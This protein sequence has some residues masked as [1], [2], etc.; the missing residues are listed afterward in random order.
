M[1]GRQQYNTPIPPSPI[2]SIVFIWSLQGSK[3]MA[4]QFNVQLRRYMEYHKGSCVRWTWR[5][6][7][8]KALLRF[9]YISLLIFPVLLCFLDGQTR[10]IWHCQ[11]DS[12]AVLSPLESHQKLVW[13]SWD[14]TSFCRVLS[15]VSSGFA[16]IWGIALL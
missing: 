3:N 15:T 10:N 9:A 16:F 6:I 7:V 12:V 1:P 8:S 11:P 4:L 2:A 13:T 5:L 14:I